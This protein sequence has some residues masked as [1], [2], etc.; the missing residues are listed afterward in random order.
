MPLLLRGGRDTR[1]TKLPRGWDESAP[2][3][4]QIYHTL[5][6]EINLNRMISFTDLRTSDRLIDTLSLRYSGMARHGEA[7]IED[8]ELRRGRVPRKSIAVLQGFSIY[9]VLTWPVAKL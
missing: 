2:L 1:D 9:Q 5:F 6:L 8:S 7:W 3:N 4:P